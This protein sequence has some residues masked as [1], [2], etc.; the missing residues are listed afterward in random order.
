MNDYRNSLF[1]VVYPP[2]TRKKFERVSS[3]FQRKIC[4]VV[5]R[6]EAK[7]VQQLGSKQIYNYVNNK[8]H[9]VKGS[10]LNIN[11]VPILK[12]DDKVNKLADFF[13]SVFSIDDGKLPTT[14]FVPQTVVLEFLITPELV[15]R[16]ARSLKPSCNPTTDGIPQVVYKRCIKGMAIPLCHL[17]NFSLHLSTIPREWSRSIVCPVPK[18]ACPQSCSDFP[19][20]SLTSGAC[21]LMEKCVKYRM[22][23]HFHSNHVLPDSQFGFRH[24]SSTTDQL[25]L[26]STL[27]SLQLKVSDSKT[28][29]LHIGNKNP[30]HLYRF[31]NGELALA[32]AC[33]KD[34]G[35]VI[36]S[37]LT[38]ST[39]VATIANR[40]KCRMHQLLR[41]FSYSTSQL[42]CMLF[43]VYG[44]PIL[45][46][47]SI[48]WN[49][50]LKKY[51]STREHTTL[52]YQTF[53]LSMFP[54]Q[55]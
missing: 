42:L 38:F 6:R 48:I 8:L 1:K 34:L 40:A 2:W 35:V 17:Y 22:E 52:V 18:A 44:L 27:D 50:H 33:N 9:T 37:D 23:K 54:Y 4:C 14:D 21:K 28:K 11:G 39:H 5:R 26:C 45:E 51:R 32:E 43:D 30:R 25:L 16:A 3:L 19:P 10:S 36:S 20:I 53:L 24:N 46:Y 47:S 7:I 15:H 49:P 29:M 31:A 13:S 55:E 41:S 12:D